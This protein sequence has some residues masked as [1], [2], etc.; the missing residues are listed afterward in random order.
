MSA[1]ALPSVFFEVLVWYKYALC[2]GGR[3]PDN[4]LQQQKTAHYLVRGGKKKEGITAAAREDV[5]RH[6]WCWCCATEAHAMDLV[7]AFSFAHTQ[8]L[9]KK[10]LSVRHGGPQFTGDQTI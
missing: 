9:I 1:W 8:T 7:T 6:A 5:L 3:R 2:T 10:L 4:K